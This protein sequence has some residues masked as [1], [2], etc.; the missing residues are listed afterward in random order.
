MVIAALL[1]FVILLIAWWLA[2]DESRRSAPA[3]VG[4]EGGHPATYQPQ[5]A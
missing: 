2:P 1:S 3:V 4:P 5:T